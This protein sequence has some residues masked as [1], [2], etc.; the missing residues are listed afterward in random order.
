MGAEL[1][2]SLALRLP[3]EAAKLLL[4][5]AVTEHVA[6]RGRTHYHEAAS[7]LGRATPVIGQDE[8]TSIA[9]LLMQDFPRLPALKD[10]LRQAGLL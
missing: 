9:R 6:G 10:E 8:V 2:G 5:R 1:I 3:A 7:L 4:L